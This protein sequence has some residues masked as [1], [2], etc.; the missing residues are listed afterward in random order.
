MLRRTR[1][2]LEVEEDEGRE[3]ALEKKEEPDV[4]VKEEQ[5]LGVEVI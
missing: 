3:L 5:R 1:G 2:E 4:E